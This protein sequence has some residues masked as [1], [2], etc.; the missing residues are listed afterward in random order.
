METLEHA[1]PISLPQIHF[2]SV[3]LIH[4]R[5]SGT[6]IPPSTLE[7]Q[8]K[9]HVSEIQSFAASS[10]KRGMRHR[11]PSLKLNY[12]GFCIHQFYRRL[13]QMEEGHCGADMHSSNVEL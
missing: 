9:I 5:G 4:Q 13:F 11:F 1:G 6:D 8:H 10:H 12:L 7:N 2:F 3:S